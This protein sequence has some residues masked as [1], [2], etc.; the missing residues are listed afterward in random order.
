MFTMEGMEVDDSHEDRRCI[1][2]INAEYGFEYARIEGG[3]CFESDECPKTLETA[4]YRRKLRRN[5]ARDPA[6]FSIVI[7][8]DFP[9]VV[10]DMH[11][12]T[13]NNCIE[14]PPSPVT[15]TPVPGGKEV[16]YSPWFIAVLAV[17]VLGLIVD[18]WKRGR[19][20]PTAAVT[21]RSGEFAANPRP[22]GHVEN[23]YVVEM[24]ECPNNYM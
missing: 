2:P 8:L 1:F 11:N 10:C 12:I 5:L 23:K 7:N 3:I 17:L 15:T 24:V 21:R 19:N 6:I 16:D 9:E 20:V 4:N 22:A 13:G 18:R 14:L